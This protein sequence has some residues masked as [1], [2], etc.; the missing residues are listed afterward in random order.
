[1]TESFQILGEAVAVTG[2]D[3]EEAKQKGIAYQKV[4]MTD[5]SCKFPDITSYSLKVLFKEGDGTVIGAQ[6]VGIGN[7]AGLLDTFTLAI[8]GHQTVFDLES[9]ELCEAGE[10]PINSIGAMGS[11]SLRMDCPLISWEKVLN[12]DCAEKARS[13]VIADCILI[14]VREQEGYNQFHVPG[15]INVPVSSLDTSLDHIKQKSLVYVYC[16][17]SERSCEATWTLRS[18]NF[19]SFSVSGG[20]FSYHL[21]KDSLPHKD[22]IF[23]GCECNCKGN[24]MKEGEIT[25]EK[26]L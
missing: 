13:K 24:S 10:H 4:Y 20:L 14:D 1:M 5:S 12:L 22:L 11:D 18:R 3:E 7:V 8:Q 25:L 2:F 6:C 19:N 21:L 17:D 26:S 15:S 23:F 9:S 16:E